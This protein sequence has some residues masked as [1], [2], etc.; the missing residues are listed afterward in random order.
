MSDPREDVR[1][2]L[3]RANLTLAFLSKF[4]PDGKTHLFEPGVGAGLTVESVFGAV[5]PALFTRRG[6]KS[7]IGK[8][9]MNRLQYFTPA[10]AKPGDKPFY[11]ST[12]SPLLRLLKG[13]GTTS[14]LVQ[15]LGGEIFGELVEHLHTLA[16][17]FGSN[18][19]R[20]LY[21]F[22]TGYAFLHAK[23]QEEHKKDSNSASND[24]LFDSVR[25]RDSLRDNP[26]FSEAIVDYMTCDEDDQ[27]V[28]SERLESRMKGIENLEDY[29]KQAYL[30]GF[31]AARDCLSAED[32]ADDTYTT[33]V[34]QDK[35]NKFPWLEN[36]GAGGEKYFVKGVNTGGKNFFSYYARFRLS[37]GEVH[38]FVRAAP[39]H[40][41]VFCW[42]ASCYHPYDDEDTDREKVAEELFEWGIKFKGK[43]KEDDGKE[44]GLDRQDR[45][46]GQTDAQLADEAGWFR[47]SKAI[48]TEDEK[49]RLADDNL[50]KEAQEDLIR[51]QIEFYRPKWSYDREQLQARLEN[52][53][54]SLAQSVGGTRA[55]IDNRIGQLRERFQPFKNALLRACEDRA[56]RHTLPTDFTAKLLEADPVEA[57]HRARAEACWKPFL[58]AASQAQTTG[59][60]LHRAFINALGSREKTEQGRLWAV[61]QEKIRKEGLHKR[62]L[63]R[64]RRRLL[65][66]ESKAK[67]SLMSGVIHTSHVETNGGRSS[68]AREKE[69]QRAQ[70]LQAAA[71]QSRRKTFETPHNSRNVEA[72]NALTPN[73]AH[74]VR[75]DNPSQ[76]PI[77]EL[78]VLEDSLK[79]DLE[80]ALLVQESLKG[81]KEE[82][83]EKASPKLVV[84][85]KTGDVALED[86]D[87][88]A[89]E[90]AEQ[91]RQE[92][93]GNTVAD[94]LVDALSEVSQT[95]DDINGVYV[96]ES[97]Q[98]ESRALRRRVRTLIFGEFID[99]APA[100]T[101]H[102]GLPHLSNM[103]ELMLQL[104]EHVGETE[105]TSTSS[106]G[107]LPGLD[108]VN[109]SR[110]YPVADK[111]QMSKVLTYHEGVCKAA[112]KQR[113]YLQDV[114]DL[115]DVARAMEATKETSS[116]LVVV[117]ATLGE[118]SQVPNYQNFVTSGCEQQSAG[119]SVTFDKFKTPV[120]LYLGNESGATKDA[121]NK[122]G[123]SLLAAHNSEDGKR[124]QI[125]L[126]VSSQRLDLPENCSYPVID[127]KFQLPRLSN[128]PA[129]DPKN[130]TDNDASTLVLDDPVV[131]NAHLA[132][133]VALSAPGADLGRL[134]T[135][136]WSKKDLAGWKG[137][138]REPRDWDKVSLETALKVIGL[139]F[140]AGKQ[141]AGVF[142]AYW[143]TNPELR[144][145]LLFAR[146][147]SLVL[148]LRRAEGSTNPKGFGKILQSAQREDFEAAVNGFAVGM[149]TAEN[150]WCGSNTLKRKQD[151]VIS[152]DLPY[153]LSQ[154]DTDFSKLTNWRLPWKNAKLG[155]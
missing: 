36:Y 95:Q 49:Q 146:W 123:A 35:G 19:P 29:E 88:F 102:L 79:L 136:T 25:W 94:A 111:A 129:L 40:S 87:F 66:Q 154:T 138:R 92:L 120:A 23:T 72:V 60:Q 59:E 126:V 38:R 24:E 3:E 32:A 90:L 20:A 58:E 131:T 140:V 149:I 125:P 6:G 65:H 148:L 103:H 112:L 13:E 83:E 137:I 37:A 56:K 135:K 12:R 42:L 107:R 68:K 121:L 67:E 130:T 81:D 51:A 124:S 33:L 109:L 9:R 151:P 134:T 22:G 77:G 76:T 141:L 144:A 47:E 98:S 115:G 43:V 1:A 26:D 64:L 5:R 4:S 50:F 52:L 39:M 85:T 48:L 7:D 152:I 101:V 30:A 142:R 63:Y 86:F 145:N 150:I 110:A 116:R 74:E 10:Q 139:Q 97:N 143:F 41:F 53:W 31:K 84:S 118:H 57:E 16:C 113:G 119:T 78:I 44:K 153:G 117:D 46:F 55:A 11:L 133:A 70:K 106:D 155:L 108:E 17:F 104:I 34:V 54:V 127:A 45:V 61:N 8:T 82:G 2:E 71:A 80:K 69:Q 15:S 21:A 89:T 99:G 96:S 132:L 14:K 75:F 91:I 100:D 128:V 93:A 147:L 73:V 114:R 105:G 28:A 122:F 18:F 62:R 27:T